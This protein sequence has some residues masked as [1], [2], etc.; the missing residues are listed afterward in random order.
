MMNNYKQISADLVQLLGLSS[1]PV[2]MSF[3]N[4]AVPGIPY[5]E[6]DYPPPTPDGRTGAVSA[7]CVFW[8]EAET[9]TFATVPADHGNC[10]VGCLTHGLKS[11]EEVAENADVQAVCEA[12]WV[13]P[14]IFP[15]IPVVKTKSEFIRYGPLADTT[16][17]PDVIL[18]RVI[19]KQAMQIQ[20][21]LGQVRFE[22]K[23]QCHVVA[24]AKEHGE[25]VIST[26]CMLS[27]A[28]TRMS[29]NEMTCAIPESQLGDLVV[30]L[31]KVCES[32][33]AVAS[34]AANDSHRF[35]LRL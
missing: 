19:P 28:R 4:E 21:A 25:I 35:S 14:E 13:N 22:G 17:V 20:S 5:F 10:S 33:L 29:N 16:I 2:A 1:S 31:R 30:S 11:L 27:R 3:G 26:G 15:S 24:L 9:K 6:S 23:P 32:D 7:G 34:Y 12:D 8:M 18:L